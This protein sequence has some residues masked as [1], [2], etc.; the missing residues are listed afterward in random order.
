MKKIIK[1]IGNSLGIIFDRED[2]KIHCLEEGDVV[3]FS[4]DT[5]SRKIKVE[6]NK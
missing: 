6:K 1:K 3:E 5:F 4:E 2:C